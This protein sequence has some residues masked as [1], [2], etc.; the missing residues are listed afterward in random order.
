MCLKSQKQCGDFGILLL[1]QPITILI[2][3]FFFKIELSKDD[4]LQ[5]RE[6]GSIRILIICPEL[7]GIE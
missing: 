6:I 2:K 7:T 5:K 3:I 4:I 1:V